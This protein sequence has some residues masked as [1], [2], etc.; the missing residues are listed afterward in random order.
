MNAN[1]AV[2]SKTIEILRSQGIHCNWSEQ[3]QKIRV[4]SK[5]GFT[6]I[7]GDDRFVRYILNEQYQYTPDNREM[8]YG[9]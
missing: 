3:R 1:S 7:S 8:P 6:Y 9:C 4:K 5:S 2:V